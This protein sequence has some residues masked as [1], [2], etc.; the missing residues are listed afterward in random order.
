MF[1]FPRRRGNTRRRFLLDA[2]SGSAWEGHANWISSVVGGHHGLWEEESAYRVKGSQ[3]KR[4]HGQGAWE[5]LRREALAHI[6]KVTGVAEPDGEFLP[7]GVPSP[8]DVVL[9]TAIV[10]V[11]D[12]VAS[13]GDVMPGIWGGESESTEKSTGRAEQAWRTLRLHGGWNPSSLVDDDVFGTRFAHIGSPR[14]VQTLAIDMAS[15][16]PRAGLMIVE[17]P[18][19]E[20]KTELSMAVAEIFAKKFGSD[21]VFFGLPTQATSDAILD[22]FVPWL[23]KVAPGSPVALAHGKA[24][25]NETVRN[26]PEWSSSG[27]GIDCCDD[28][29]GV[30]AVSGWFRSS[31]RLLLSPFVVGTIDNVL[32]SGSKIRHGALRFL[33]LTGKVVILDEV[34]AADVYMNKFLERALSWLGSAGV[35]VILMSAT[36]PSA[37]RFGLIEAYAGLDEGTAKDS[38]DDADGYPRVTVALPSATDEEEVL[39]ARSPNANDGSSKRPTH[40]RLRVLHEENLL[41]RKATI[42]DD[43]VADLFA[44]KL[45]G[46]GCALVIRNTVGRAQ[47]L[48]ATLKK[49]FPDAS[50]VLFHSRYTAGDKD[51]IAKRVLSR[52]GSTSKN[53]VHRP[54]AGEKFIVVATQVAEQSLDIDADVLITDLC[55]IDLLLQRVGRMWRHPENTPYRPAAFQEPEVWV[56]RMHAAAGD[57]AHPNSSPRSTPSR[58]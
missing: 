16:S 24:M 23:A 53:G 51:A 47:S 29:P 28:G 19:G 8:A 39:V 3:S 43:A 25:I 36:L 44:R 22:R 31:K 56:T 7:M 57:Y 6:K 18:M 35:P 30:T 41:A 49:R 13:N 34:H 17:A 27:V 58:C 21:G 20:G 4:R 38:I 15:T 33:G 46:G 9:L 11:A 26:L 40:V 55:P 12:W 32:L 48:Y 52:L 14:P 10:I 37:Q 1:S 45:S 54:T 5:D 50:V 2:L 42:A